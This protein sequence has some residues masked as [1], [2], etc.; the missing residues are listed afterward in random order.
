[1]VNA[2]IRSADGPVT[3]KV[4]VA[5]APLLSALLVTTTVIAVAPRPTD[6]ASPLVELMVATA[7][8]L[9]YQATV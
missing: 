7:V 1:M 4:A 2:E 5:V 3:V 6:V 8:L 9:E